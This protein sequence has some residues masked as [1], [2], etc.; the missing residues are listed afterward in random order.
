MMEQH[1]LDIEPDFNSDIKQQFECLFTDLQNAL[2]V[3]DKAV[4]DVNALC[5]SKEADTPMKSSVYQSGIRSVL[6]EVCTRLTLAH[7]GESLSRL[8]KDDYMGFFGRQASQGDLTQVDWVALC[9]KLAKDAKSL[10]QLGLAETADKLARM[11]GLLDKYDPPFYR[12]GQFVCSVSRY[13]DSY[14]NRANYET[15]KTQFKEVETVTGESMNLPI[16]DDVVTA[17]NRLNIM[18]D[19]LPSRTK[20]GSKG[21]ALHL[22]WFKNKTEFCFSE[23]AFSALVAF[24]GS[25]QPHVLSAFNMP[26]AA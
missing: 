26:N 10:E 4:N 21:Q 9:D 8:H 17:L 14:A 11:L 16:F 22:I 23:P 24:I 20:F 13:G 7:R 5:Y 2:S 25:Y 12:G 3:L 1:A 15:Y 19:E 18:D 6:N